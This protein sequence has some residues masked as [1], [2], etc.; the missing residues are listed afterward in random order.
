[1]VQQNINL[2]ST[3]PYSG[4][5][6][7]R[8]TM[9]SLQYLTI[10]RLGISS[11][12]NSTCQSMHNPTELDFMSVKDILRHIKGT[13]DHGWLSWSDSHGICGR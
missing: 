6:F 11:A 4:P 9:G 8:S 7:Y 10:T 13:L 5:Y 12:V 2:V 1:M 3:I